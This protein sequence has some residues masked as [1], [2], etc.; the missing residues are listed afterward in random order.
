MDDFTLQQFTA[1]DEASSTASYVNALEAFDSIVQLQELKSIARRQGGFGPG[2]S[3]LDV[4]CGFGLETLRLAAIS[5]TMGNVAGIDKSESFIKNARERATAA[6]LTID[7]RVADATALPFDDATFDCV[8]AER[9]L[10]Y[11]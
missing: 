7:F 10:I 3:I 4:G 1:L 5:P 9:L 11:L 2:K 6:S 8:R